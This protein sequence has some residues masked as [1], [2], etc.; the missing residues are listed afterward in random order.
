MARHRCAVP[1]RCAVCIMR[2]NVGRMLGALS[3]VKTPRGVQVVFSPPPVPVRGAPHVCG[4][5]C[6]RPCPLRSAPWVRP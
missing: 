4:T 6:A 1:S 3:A 2:G 5:S